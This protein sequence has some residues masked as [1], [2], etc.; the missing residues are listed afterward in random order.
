M[1]MMR[2]GEFARHNF[3]TPSYLIEP[4]LPQGG[5]AILHGKPNVG[6]TQLV[7][8]IAHAINNGLPLFGK[9]PTRQGSVVIIQA[10]MTGQIQQ[11]RV[12]RISDA[13][14]CIE[15][16]FWLVEEDGSQ[17]IVNIIN[18]PLTHAELVEEIQTLSPVLIV[19]DTLRKIHTLSENA[20]ES[21]IAVYNA[22]R[23]VCRTATHLFIHHDRKESRDPDMMGSPDEAFMGNQ[24]WMGACDTTLSL[25]EIGSAPKRI[26]LQIHKARTADEIQKAPFSLELDMDTMLLLP[27]RLIFPSPISTPKES[28]FSSSGESIRLPKGASH[29]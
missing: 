8:T 9:W 19:W 10:D 15:E 24:Q 5:T 7:L 3:P 13:G 21:A 16:T 22:A 6:K 28:G 29:G 23:K 14:L 12:K 25:K 27:T 17:P 11:A 4:I 1:K 2:T 18:M 20:S 26:A